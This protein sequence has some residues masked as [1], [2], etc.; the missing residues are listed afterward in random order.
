V[1]KGSRGSVLAASVILVLGCAASAQAQTTVGQLAPAN[2]PLVCSGE[3]FDVTQGPTAGANPYVIP[4]AGVITSWSTNAAA[5]AGQTLAFKVYRPIGA[6]NYEVLA[7]QGPVGLTASVLNTFPVHIPVQ[8]GDVLG[9]NTSTGAG[10]PNAC[11]FKASPSDFFAATAT[12][13]NNPD[14]SIAIMNPIA[15]GF[16][17]NV[18][19][20]LQR[21]PSITSISPAGAPIKG[22]AIVTISGAELN[23][24]SAVSFGSTPAPSFTV[25]SESLITAIV[26]ASKTLA[27]GAVSVT[28]IA[29]TATSTTPFSYEGCKVPNL[30]GKKLKAAKKALKKADCKIGTVTKKEGATAHTGK[31]K[32]QSPK[33]GRVLAPGSKV[34]VTLKP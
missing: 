20:T 29:G 10:I 13:S 24:A 11:L 28:T 1:R 19:A 4:A 34:K 23:G 14:G 2:P 17:L 5:G 8:A 12:P 25:D 6:P 18:Q 21:L 16:R 22:G 27:K 3:S 30:V 32:K 26:P 15:P 7:H 31:V 33:A 9:L